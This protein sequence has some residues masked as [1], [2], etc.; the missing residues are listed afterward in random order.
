MKVLSLVTYW[1]NLPLSWKLHNT[2]HVSLLSPYHKISEYGTGYS[3]P[4]L[5]LIEGE[6]EWEVD[7]ILAA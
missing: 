2:F 3:T 4:A 5:D 7:T 1:L 6:P